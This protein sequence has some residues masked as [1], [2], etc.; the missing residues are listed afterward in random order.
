MFGAGGVVDAEDSLMYE[1]RMQEVSIS[2]VTKR[3]VA[4]LY[5]WI[6]Q[7]IVIIPNIAAAGSP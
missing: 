2:Y 7:S 6:R 5:H 4:F 3:I 1:A